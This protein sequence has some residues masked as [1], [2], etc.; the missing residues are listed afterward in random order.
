M[1]DINHIFS[2]NESQKRVFEVIGSAEGLAAWWTLT[3]V[4]M[5]GPGEI[6]DLNF[7]P[8]CLWQAE[9]TEYKPH[10]R[11]EW[12]FLDADPDWMNTRVGFHLDGTDERTEVRFYHGGWH[13]E[14]DHFRTSCYCW[15]MY[16]RI[17]KRYIE[18]NEFVAYDE[19]LTV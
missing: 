17:L 11:F 15:A 6:Y 7:G 1:A 3:A 16:L 8:G 12:T 4:G 9:V 13:Q 18:F 19:R 10:S 5:P 14:N 2:I